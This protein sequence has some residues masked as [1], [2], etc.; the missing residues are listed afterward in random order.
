MS[1]KPTSTPR[2]AAPGDD[3]NL[4]PVDATTA[5]SFEDRAFQFW[6]KNRIVMI[7]CFAVIIAA[8]IVWWVM[9]AM[10]AGRLQEIQQAY[11][12]ATTIEAKRAFATANAGHPLAGLALLAVADDSYTNMRYDEAARDYATAAAELT[13]PLLSG[14]A[15]LGEGMARVKAGQTVEGERVLTTL[16]EDATALMSYRTQA[17][18]ELAAIAAGAGDNAK[19]LVAADKARALDPEGYWAS[20]ATVLRTRLGATDMPVPPATDALT[21]PAPEA[22]AADAAPA[23][24]TPAP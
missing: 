1:E 14:R 13:E 15:R 19:A 3:R 5:V 11:G 22:P 20:M 7:G 18:Y 10:E 8:M 6:K 4:V 23:P 16:A 9:R 17:W 21:A 2:A 12:E 24:A